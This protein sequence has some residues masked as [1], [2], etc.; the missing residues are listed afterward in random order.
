VVRGPEV[1]RIVMQAVLKHDYVSSHT[2]NREMSVT[3]KKK[4]TEN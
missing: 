2:S 3:A 4:S 1:A